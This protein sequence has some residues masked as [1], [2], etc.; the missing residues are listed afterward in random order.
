MIIPKIIHQ[1]WD[2]PDDKEIP[3]RLQILSDTF[4]EKNPEWEYHLWG[5]EEMRQLVK[6]HYPEFLPVYD[7]FKEDILRWDSIRY[8]IL[9][10]CGGVYVDFDIECL[11]PLDNLF[12][13][14]YQMYIGEEPSNKSPYPWL[15]NVLGN[16]FMASVPAC[17][18]W[19]DI[20]K[21]VEKSVGIYTKGRV[22]FDITGSGMLTRTFGK[23]IPYGAYAIPYE[24]VSPIRKFD[25]LRYI[26]Y[27]YTQEFEQRIKGAYCIHYFLGTWDEE[28]GLY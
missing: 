14:D 16:G 18:G 19:I 10:H 8:M 26:Y 1:T 22:V 24:L 28:L 23:L 6:D 12:E 13:N 3:I 15:R 21:E 11:K 4:R 25:S 20:L 7:G 9:H 5:R 2:N 27:K 17:Q